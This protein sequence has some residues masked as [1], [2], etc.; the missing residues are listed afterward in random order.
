MLGMGAQLELLAQHPAADALYRVDDACHRLLGR[1]LHQEV[2]VI[3]LAVQLQQHAVEL[4]RHALA[5][6][7]HPLDLGVAQD[8]ASVFDGEDQVDDKPRNAVPA[9]AGLV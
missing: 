2:N 8:L 9:P 3:G 1:V 7:P 4:L 5:D 6:L